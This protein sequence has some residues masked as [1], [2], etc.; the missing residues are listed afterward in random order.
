MTIKNGIFSLVILLF[1]GLK[2]N[3]QYDLS[4]YKLIIDGKEVK[5]KD[6]DTTGKS[7]SH[8]KVSFRSDE[9][10]SPPTL[11]ITSLPDGYEENVGARMDSISKSW[12]DKKIPSF[13]LND[14]S[15][16]TINSASLRGKVV[17][18]NFYF[19]TCHPCL[20][21]MPDLNKLEE[22]YQNK[23]V[24]FLA[25]ALENSAQLKSFLKKNKFLYTQI[26]NG[27]KY[28]KASFRID[29]W[30]THIV[31]D[32]NGVIKYFSQGLDPKTINNL[33]TKIVELS[34]K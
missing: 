29:M 8:S 22:K 27:E 34:A 28:T 6:L 16:K 18:M 24:V 3:A 32:Q 21:E 17:V 14:L 2:S 4:K 13:K 19:T 1:V 31:A 7:K 10:T 30:P 23:N 33:D 5:F 26:P 15:G 9:T 11:Y 20:Q 25:F 12:I